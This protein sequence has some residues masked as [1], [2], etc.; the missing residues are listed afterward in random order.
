MIKV[1]N[2]SKDFVGKEKLSVLKDI[3]LQ[4]DEGDF[5]AI[6]GPSGGW[7]RLIPLGDPRSFGVSIN[8]R[9]F[10]M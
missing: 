8:T 3:D 9:L 6:I 10:A 7:I 2:L 5:V 1:N 4:I